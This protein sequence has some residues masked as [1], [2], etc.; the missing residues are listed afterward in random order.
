MK[1]DERQQDGQM[2]KDWMSARNVPDRIYERRIADES[3]L[4]STQ[5]FAITEIR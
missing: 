3:H 4:K 1:M 2:T 5:F